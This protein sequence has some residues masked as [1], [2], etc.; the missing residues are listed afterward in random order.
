MIV[1]RVMSV[2][3]RKTYDDLVTIQGRYH[4]RAEITE[5]ANELMERTTETRGSAVSNVFLSQFMI[6]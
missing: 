5:V 4:L 6:Q 3:G 2:I 1:D